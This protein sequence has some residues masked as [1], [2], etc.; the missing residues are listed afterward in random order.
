MQDA[1]SNPNL[2]DGVLGHWSTYVV[3]AFGVCIGLGTYIVLGNLGSILFLTVQGVAV[4]DLLMDQQAV[5]TNY[6]SALLGANAIGLALGLGATAL[7]ASRLDSSRPL[8]YLRFTRCTWRTLLISIL[9]FVFLLPVV[10]GLGI[11]N[12]QVRLPQVLQQME[13]QQMIL[14]EWLASGGGNYSLNL[15]LVAVTPAFFEEIFFRGFI[16]RRAQRG[17]G[18]AGGIL[19]TGIVFGIFHLRLTQVLPLILLG[20]FL[21]YLAWRTG[22]LWIPVIL[23]FLNNGLMLTVSELGV[24]SISD[25]EQV[26]WLL[27]AGSTVAFFICILFI[28][29]GHGKRHTRLG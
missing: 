8:E 4:A 19:F 10:L 6:G 23:H 21:A 15:L 2:F 20:C 28:H 24:Q 27:V 29:R 7:I 16:L 3:I 17:M 13:A 11:L 14:V 22:S 25:P 26:S 18:A 12:E 5:V 1:G 9:A